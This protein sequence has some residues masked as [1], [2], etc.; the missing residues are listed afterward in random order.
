MT[1]GPGFLESIELL[2]AS[3]IR[4]IDN[5]AEEL[6]ELVIEM[7]DRIEGR[8]SETVQERAAPAHFA[9]I[10]AVHNLYP[11]RVASCFLSRHPQLFAPFSP[12]RCRVG[13]PLGPGGSSTAGE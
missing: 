12:G 6:R 13:V 10:A 2:A 11:A 9:K 3:G 4:V 5:S 7:V 1:D 8:H